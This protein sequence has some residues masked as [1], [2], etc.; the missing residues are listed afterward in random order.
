MPYKKYALVIAIAA[1]MISSCTMSYSKSGATTPTTSP[2]TKPLPTGDNTMKNVEQYAT[3]TAMAKTA[4]AEG[5]TVSTPIGGTPVVPN[6]L[7]TSTPVIVGGATLTP[8]LAVACTAPPPCG[9]GQALVCA[10]G[11]CTGGC[12]MVCAPVTA[13][14]TPASNLAWPTSWTLHTGEFPYC[15]ARRYNIDPEYLIN[16]PR[17]EWARGVTYFT[18][19]Q[20]L[21]IPPFN[22]VNPSH[23]F[24]GELALR[25]HPT[26]YTVTSSD[27]TMY[28]IAC[29]FGNV[30]PAQIAQANGLALGSPLTIGQAIKIP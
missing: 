9:A 27:E 17:N 3:Q 29:L 15:I 16:Y 20:V 4:V 26:T 24:P 28:S 22:E 14:F 10:S 5:G 2:F 11:N 12:G 23:R 25:P 7:V 1:L 8:T 21:Q 19:G 30:D 18:A 13:T 6:N